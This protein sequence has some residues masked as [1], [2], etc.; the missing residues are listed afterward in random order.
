MEDV[1][2]FIVLY[3]FQIWNF[4]NNGVG[5]RSFLPLCYKLLRVFPVS[6]SCL[7]LNVYTCT[8]NRYRCVYRQREL[9]EPRLHCVVWGEQHH[10]QVHLLYCQQLSLPTGNLSQ[11]LQTDFFHNSAVSQGKHH[12]CLSCILH[13]I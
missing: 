9:S 13:E 12:F 10:R 2:L 11:W 1:R 4:S 8:G 5:F 3:K 7:P 6:M